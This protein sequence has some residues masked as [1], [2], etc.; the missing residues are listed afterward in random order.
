MSN[1]LGVLP[2][3]MAAHGGT[4]DDIPSA[5]LVAAGLTLLQRSAPLVRALYGKRAAPV[6]GR[7]RDEKLRARWQ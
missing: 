6:T 5:Q 4:L 7:Q 1:P 2:L 3:A